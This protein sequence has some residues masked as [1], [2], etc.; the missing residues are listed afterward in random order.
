MRHLFSHTSSM[1]A[2]EVWYCNASVHRIVV[3][4]DEFSTLHTPDDLDITQLSCYA[5]RSIFEV[6]LCSLG[7]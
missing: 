1:F 4:L 6:D 7:L 2:P 5:V 3:I